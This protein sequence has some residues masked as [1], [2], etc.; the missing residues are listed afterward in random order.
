[1]R[2]P[3]ANPQPRAG[4]FHSLNLLQNPRPN[5]AEFGSC[6]IDTHTNAVASN[7]LGVYSR[8][9]SPEW[10][11]GLAMHEEIGKTAGA[12]EKY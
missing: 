7:Y 6:L 4:T 1:M 11:R 8:K 10:T 5:P 12:D 2:H 9:A 3:G